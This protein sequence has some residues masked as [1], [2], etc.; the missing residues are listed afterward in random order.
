M[1]SPTPATR[2]AVASH[3]LSPLGVALLLALAPAASAQLTPLGDPSYSVETYLTESDT[4]LVSK[5]GL[6]L[7]D[8][9]SH[10]DAEEGAVSIVS[11]LGLD[12]DGDLLTNAAGVE[13]YGVTFWGHANS[14]P[15]GSAA[16]QAGY[17]GSVSVVNL[18]QSYRK[19]AFDARLTFTYTGGLLSLVWRP[20]DA[21]PPADVE[22]FSARAVWEYTVYDRGEE[23]VYELQ[24]ARLER[25]FGGWSLL[26]TGTKLRFDEEL[27]PPS[28]WDWLC[29][30][31]PGEPYVGSA[32]LYDFT[33]AV[34]LSTI[35]VGDEF[36]VHH[37]LRVHAFNDTRVPRHVAFA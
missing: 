33:R 17:K 25:R 22:G 29:C 28:Y 14:P 11:E 30:D 3:R 2:P 19:D 8:A 7:Q 34:D 6:Y 13:N 18:L 10:E 21:P 36:T 1:P 27:E 32:E 24:E 12:L 20:I 26:V 5:F 35:A 16:R 9:A 15:Q 37:V 31:I 23:E 4:N